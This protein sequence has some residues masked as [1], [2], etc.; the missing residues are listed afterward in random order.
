MTDETPVLRN[1]A[2]KFWFRSFVGITNHIDEFR[3]PVGDADGD[4]Q[5][6]IP[7]PERAV[8]RTLLLGLLLGRANP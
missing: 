6:R 4:A 2:Q 8:G 3:P 7:Q 5:A 1:D